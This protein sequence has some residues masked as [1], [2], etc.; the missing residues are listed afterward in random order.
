M[1]LSVRE[2][3]RRAVELADVGRPALQALAD[4]LAAERERAMAAQRERAEARRIAT[5]AGGARVRGRSRDP[6]ERADD[7]LAQ[8]GARMLSV[9]R[10][11]GGRMLDVTCEI[12]GER[13]IATVDADSLQV[14]DAGICLAG[15]DREITLDSLPSVVREAIEENHLNITRR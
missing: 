5:V 12:D 4:Q 6:I 9:R 10:L 1:T 15:A 13:I 2:L 3:M 7:A 14:Y 8:A 11:Q